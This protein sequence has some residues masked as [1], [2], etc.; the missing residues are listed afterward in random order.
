MKPSP[1]AVLPPLL[2]M[3]C[4]TWHQPEPGTLS[5]F[6]AKTHGDCVELYLPG[7]T[8]PGAVRLGLGDS[9]HSAAWAD[10]LHSRLSLGH[11][12][13]RADTIGLSFP[14]DSLWLNLKFGR[15]TDS[16]HGTIQ[17]PHSLVERSIAGRWEPCVFRDAVAR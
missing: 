3:G 7:L 10:V 12:S 9:V 11:W 2:A 14:Q 8:D 4:L 13:I 15:P 16:L 6:L 17:G 5:Q 1:I